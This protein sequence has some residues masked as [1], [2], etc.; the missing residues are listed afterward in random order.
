MQR[1]SSGGR[2]TGKRGTHGQAVGRAQLGQVWALKA[3]KD[4]LRRQTCGHICSLWGKYNMK[5]WEEGQLGLF[6]Q[7]GK[8]S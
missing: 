8:A 2:L 5:I 4:E 7:S 1:D 6:D 3:P